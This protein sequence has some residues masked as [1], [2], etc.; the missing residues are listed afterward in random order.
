MWQDDARK[1]SKAMQT[2]WNTGIHQD[3]YFYASSGRHMSAAELRCIQ[4][5]T[6]KVMWSQPKLLRSSLLYVD[7]HLVCLSEDGVLRLIRVAPESY[8]LVSQLVL[9]RGGEPARTAAATEASAG[10]LLQYPAWAAP[11]LSHGLLYV[12]GKDRLVCLEL[13]PAS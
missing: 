1:R 12:R 13:I 8:Q 3:G 10:M 6:G 9:Y 11:I 2:H 7:G 4:W 5:R